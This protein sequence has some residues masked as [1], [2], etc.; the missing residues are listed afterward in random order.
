MSFPNSI[1]NDSCYAKPN[2]TEKDYERIYTDCQ[3]GIRQVS[4]RQISQKYCE[5]IKDYFPSN[6]EERCLIDCPPGSFSI[7]IQGK[8]ISCDESNNKKNN[9]CLE[10][11]NTNYERKHFSLKV[12]NS[13]KIFKQIC[14]SNQTSQCNEF[15]GFKFSR[16]KFISG[17]NLPAQIKLRLT[18]EFQVLENG[19]LFYQTNLNLNQNESFSFKIKIKGTVKGKF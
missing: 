1:G 9:S 3:N 19:T 14:K 10:C 7:S 12:E 6:Y 4:Y 2:C 18:L 15:L 16:N 5:Y 13:W 17:I 11:P 8:C